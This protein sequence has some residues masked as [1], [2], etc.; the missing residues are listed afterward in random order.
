MSTVTDSAL[1]DLAVNTIRMLS[2]DAV[3]KANSGHPGLPMGAADFAFVLFTEFLK[4]DPQDP[5]WKTAERAHV[6]WANP[7]QEEVSSR[8]SPES[9]N[10]SS[11]Q[12]SGVLV[13]SKDGPRPSAGRSSPLM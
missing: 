10:A 6:Q 8:C 5:D 3:Q 9:G 12:F 11:D 7:L 2:A 1:E 13:K 4:F